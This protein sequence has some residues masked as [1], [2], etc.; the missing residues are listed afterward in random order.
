MNDRE[1]TE[2]HREHLANVT[3]EGKRIWLYPRILKGKLYRYREILSYVLL[4]L[5]FAGPFLRIGG[6]PLLLFNVVERKFVFFG[7]PFWP[8]D[9]YLLAVL[10][11]TAVLFVVLF[12]VIFGRVWCG[13]TC[14]QT[15]FMEMVFRRIEKLIEGSA[16]QRR[17]LDAMPWNAHKIFKKSLKHGVFFLIS[18]AIN[19]VIKLIFICFITLSIAKHKCAHK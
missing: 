5:L 3:Q 2:N 15:I 19:Y 16:K 11:I 8:Q 9:F 17:K 12:T 10:M 4:G 13:W 14:P 18:F 7:K 1:R 6:Q